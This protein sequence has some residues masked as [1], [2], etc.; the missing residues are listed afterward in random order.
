MRSILKLFRFIHANRYAHILGIMV[1]SF[2]LILVAC[3]TPLLGAR[4]TNTPLPTATPPPTVTATAT[5]TKTPTST[6]TPT[7]T[8]SPTLTSTATGTATSTPTST[9]KHT[10]TPTQTA[11]RTPYFIIVELAYENGTLGDQLR[12]EAQKAQA[13]GLKPFAD[14]TAT[15]CP[16]CQAIVQSLDEKNPLMVD[17]FNGTYII[18]IDV[19]IWSESECEEAGFFLEYIPIFFRLDADGKPT[20]DTIDGNAWGENTPENMAPPLKGFFQAVY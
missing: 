14:F 18:R 15:W 16:P 3:K 20:G 11:T 13:L 10:L 7:N 2:P 17:A 12:N 19:D 9:A 1:F 5:L 6:S 8:P 4:V